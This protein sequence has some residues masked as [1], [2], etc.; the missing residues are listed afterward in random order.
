MASLRKKPNSRFWIACF[1]DHEGRQRQR[2]TGTADRTEAMR[3]ALNYEEVHS[4]KMTEQQIRRVLN[5]ISENL[6]GRR[7]ATAGVSEYLARWLARKQGETTEST[8]TRYQEVVRR[9]ESFLGPKRSAQDVSRLDVSDFAKFRDELAKTVTAGTTNLCIKIMSSAMKA[10]WREGLI[11]DNPAAKIERLKPRR[12][13]VDRRRPFTLKELKTLLEAANTEWQGIILCGIYT[14]Q[15]LGDIVR[16][17]WRDVDLHRREI[18]FQTQKTGRVVMLPLAKPLHSHFLSLPSA[19]DPNAPVFPEAFAVV[20]KEGRVNNLSNAFYDLLV[21]ARLAD[22]RSA[23]KQREGDGRAV[24]RQQNELVFHSL[25][26]TATSLFK[27]AGV[28]DSVVMD[29]IGHDS[30]AVSRHYTHID[31]D[32]KRRAF[33]MLPDIMAKP[34]KGRKRKGSRA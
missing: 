15:R 26:H 7:F 27:N 6:N 17:C 18:R 13:D 10:A 12:K 29:I 34:A 32:A 4:R 31:D 14:G 3:A 5:D 33:A 19:D 16:L 9:F 22:E 28:S 8:L 24:R 20:T 23:A 25:R 30:K 2:S 1:T 21:T 11:G